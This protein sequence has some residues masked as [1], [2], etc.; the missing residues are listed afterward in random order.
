M[1]YRKRLDEIERIEGY[2]TRAPEGIWCYE[3]EDPVDTRLPVEEQYRVIFETAR[4][5]H[6]NDTLARMYGYRTAEELKGTLLKNIHSFENR[7]SRIGLMEFI[8]SGY[9]IHDVE[10]EEVDPKGLK[11]F[12]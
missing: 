12:F 11:K 3:L 2:F 9:K 8:R 10:S 4:L 6:C 5:T 1:D 7:F